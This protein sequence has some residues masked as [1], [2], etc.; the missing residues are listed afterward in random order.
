MDQRGCDEEKLGGDVDVH[1]SH[2]VEKG[3]VL[4]HYLGETYSCYLDLMLRYQ[5]KKQ[6]EGPLKNSCLDVEC[7][8]RV[9]IIQKSVVVLAFGA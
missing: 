3:E 6:I 4:P 8:C 5:L 9:E 7:H 2:F 1:L